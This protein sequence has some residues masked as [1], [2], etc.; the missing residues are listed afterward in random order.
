MNFVIH[1]FH[2]ACFKTALEV[3][4]GSIF[5][6]ETIKNNNNAIKVRV[7]FPPNIVLSGEQ[8]LILC[9]YDYK[10]EYNL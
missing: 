3:F 7:V 8:L 5:D 4:K 9:Q 10:E 2:L 1:K 6:L